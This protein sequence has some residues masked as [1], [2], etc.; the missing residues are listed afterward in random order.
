MAFALVMVLLLGTAQLVV[1]SLMAK[2]RSDSRLKTAEL[3]AAKLELLKSLPAQNPELSEGLKSETIDDPP[4]RDIYRLNWR[5]AEE[6]SSL[7]AIEV[8]CFSLSSGLVPTR[9]F[10]YRSEELGF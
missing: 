5:I 2:R 9:L 10:L 4:R 1:H 6:A 7:R 8:E 3:A